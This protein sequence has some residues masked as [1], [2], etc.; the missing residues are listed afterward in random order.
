[1]VQQ[2][3]AAPAI[4]TDGLSLAWMRLRDTAMHRL[5]VGHTRAMRSVVAGIFLPVWRV[6]AYTVVD[7]INVWR[8]KL[9]SRRIFREDLLVDDVGARLT[10]FTLP[11]Y[12]F[13]GRHDYTANV[14]LSRSYFDRIV[15]R[16]KG[17]YLFDD[18]AHS[19]LFEEP[20]RAT[21]ILPRAVLRRT[22]AMADG[23]STR[24]DLT[25]T[26]ES[27]RIAALCP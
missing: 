11:I 4:M 7:K 2:S 3:K 20:E 16:V 12:F 6:R 22:A 14:N 18:S 9:W 8:G 17:L 21:E 13:L 1:M 15:A 10:T 27:P 24:G 26:I 23:V 19:P 5:G 25:Q